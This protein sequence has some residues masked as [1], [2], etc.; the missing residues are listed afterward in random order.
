VVPDEERAL[1]ADPVLQQRLAKYLVLQCF[2]N[3]V[4]EDFH[5]GVAP[6][7]ACGDYS[8]VTVSSPY[9]TIPWPR[10]SR[11]NDEEM[12]RLMIDVV[13]R[14]FSFIHTFLDDT[15]RSQLL[16]FLA[17]RDPLPQWNQPMFGRAAAGTE[18]IAAEGKI[19]RATRPLTASDLRGQPG[20]SQAAIDALLALQPTTVLEALDVKGVGR[21]TTKRLLALGLLED[22]DGMQ[23]VLAR[24]QLGGQS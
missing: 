21:K 17:E 22:P 9:G 3:S 5:S 11:L 24:E 6:S 20:L 14:A 12:K 15:A 10:V 13:D 23:G 7:S 18:T 1:I 8:D 16:L 2:R 4:L 19:S